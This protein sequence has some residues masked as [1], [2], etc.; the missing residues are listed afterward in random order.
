M[1][2]KPTIV[3][4]KAIQDIKARASNTRHDIERS[5]DVGIEFVTID[6]AIH[7]TLSV[8]S[9]SPFNE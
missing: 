6:H 4:L 3:A 2:L 1:T 7:L 5:A 8:M 9:L